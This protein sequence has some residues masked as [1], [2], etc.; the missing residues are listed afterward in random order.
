MLLAPVPKRINSVSQGADIGVFVVFGLKL[1]PAVLP[2]L[3]LA[4]MDKIALTCRQAIF[5]YF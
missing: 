4:F 1:N 2:V 5:Q 3:L